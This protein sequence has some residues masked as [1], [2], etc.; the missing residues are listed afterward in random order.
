MRIY[1]VNQRA[2]TMVK[3]NH[4]DKGCTNC[5]GYIKKGMSITQKKQCE[6]VCAIAC[7][8]LCNVGYIMKEE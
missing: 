3:E 5:A 8:G 4:P 7:I 2:Y 6:D 1:D